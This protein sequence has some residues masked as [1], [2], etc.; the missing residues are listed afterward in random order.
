MPLCRCLLADDSRSQRIKED[1]ERPVGCVKP[2]LCDA[3]EATL[4][5][6]YLSKDVVEEHQLETG[7]QV[8]V[9]PIFAK[10]LVMFNVVFLCYV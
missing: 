4:R 5:E 9:N 1:L 10:K 7:R 6:E 3:K 2:V 8:S